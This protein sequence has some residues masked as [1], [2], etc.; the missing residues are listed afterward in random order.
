MMV[1]RGR[2]MPENAIKKT[3]KLT[4]EPLTLKALLSLQAIQHKFISC[5]LLIVF[6]T[7]I[8]FMGSMILNLHAGWLLFV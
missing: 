8:Y 7:V 1:Q 5:A 3:V 6:Y 2:S 4:D